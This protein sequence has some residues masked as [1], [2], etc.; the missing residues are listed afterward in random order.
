MVG[1]VAGAALSALVGA[2]VS[3]PV[4]RLGGIA[5]ALLTL[6]FALLAD[7]VLFVYWWS[8]NGASGLNVP[9]PTIFGINFTSNGA[10]FWLALV[11]LVI[12]GVAVWLVRGGTIGQELAAFRGS[13]AAAASI[14]IDVRRLRVLAFAL[15]GAVAGL[16][17]GLYASLE[18]SVSPNDFTYELSLVF[19]VLVATVGAYSIASAVEA[20][21]AFAVLQQAAISLP[22]RFSGLDALAALVFGAAALTYVRHP[23]GVAA[24]MKRWIL[25]RA[26]QFA[27]FLKR[28]DVPRSPRTPHTPAPL[29]GS[30][31]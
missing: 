24:F 30:E 21:I 12:V 27:G 31:R 1:V 6:A 26:E 20:G 11:V 23:E 7:N 5:V 14:G 2:L 28:N 16:S 18:G 15:S 3:L 17:G 9:R 4:L 29:A 13:E 10:F 22:A 25:D 19:M 8:G